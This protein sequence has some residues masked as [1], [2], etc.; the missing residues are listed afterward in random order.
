MAEV[1]EV[2]KATGEKR[3][4]TKTMRTFWGIGEFGESIGTM[5]GMMYGVFFLTDIVLV[6]PALL[7]VTTMLGSVASF[8]LTPV[9]GMIID[10][11]KPMK[12]G[13]LRSF[14]LVFPLIFLL[15]SPFSFISWG[16]PTVTALII[17][18][19][20]MIGGL[21]YTTMVTANVSLIPS[22]CAYDEEA[23]A[24]TSNRMIYASLGRMFG[25]YIAPVI[26]MAA[27]ATLGN[28]SYLVLHIAFT[29]FLFCCYLVIF[30]LSKGYEGNGAASVKISEERLTIKDMVT[31]VRI[32]PEIVPLMIA[33]I[34]SSLGSFLMPSL[35][36][37]MFTYVVE[38]GA[39]LGMMAIY[40]LVVGI[41][42]TLGAYFSRWMM[43]VIPDKRYVLYITYLPI[44][45]FVFLTR[46]FVGNVFIFIVLVAIMT[47]FMWIT[48]PPETALYYD[49]AV[50]AEAKMGKNP[51]GIFLA[52][53]QY[54]PRVAGIING[55]VLST[56]FVSMGYDPTKPITEGI[57][58]GFIN[59]FSLVTCVIPILGW[60]AMFFFFKVTPARVAQAREAIAARDAAGNA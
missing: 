16:H 39:Q 54:A 31:A 4:I 47:F 45:G 11:T 15:L 17:C 22:M 49:I 40:N 48:Q 58:M 53:A 59:A 3:H 14:V 7:A 51:I 18:F 50:I 23:N 36:I 34:T 41:V 8:V 57:K 29:L 25:G 26:I 5:M 52:L 19:T 24:L 13:K 44:A 12:W 27:I 21:V 6:P 55:I 46:F 2:A 32:T 42:G 60:L 43:K 35:V 20:G 9:A 37:Y 1:A 33:D 56:L 38:D 28:S 10:G 30:R